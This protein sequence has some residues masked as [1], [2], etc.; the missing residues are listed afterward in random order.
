MDV[1]RNGTSVEQCNL[2]NRATPQNTFKLQLENISKSFGGIKAVDNVSLEISNGVY[3][4]VGKNGAGKTTLV[5]ILMGALEPDQGVIKI[6]GNEVVFRNP[7][8]AK[9]YNI[10]MVF[11]ELSLFPNL[12]IMENISM[13]NRFPSYPVKLIN[14]R[15]AREYTKKCLERVNLDHDPGTKVEELS[16]AEQQMVEIAKAIQF[17]PSVLILDEP[18]SALSLKEQD[19]LYKTIRD[20][21]KQVS[22]IIIITHNL[23]EVIELADR[24]IVMRDGGKIFNKKVNS[25]SENEIVEAIVGKKIDEKKCDQRNGEAQKVHHGKTPL[26]KVQSLSLVRKFENMSFDVSYGEILG[27]VGL[28]GCGKSELA[29]SLFGKEACITGQIELEGKPVCFRSPREAVQRKIGYVP[30]DRKEEGL[31]HG[32]SMGGNI[33]LA[34]LNR[35]SRGGFLR[36]DMEKNLCY[37]M[38]NYMDI[39]PPMIKMTAETFSGGNQQKIILGRWL[40]AN[41]KVLI[42]DEPTRGVDVAS[43]RMIY[44]LL[45][46]LASRGLGI[47]VVSSE[48]KEVHNEADRLMVMSKGKIIQELRPFECSWEDVLAMALRGEN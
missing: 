47:V 17:N 25:T 14:W 28:E 40:A 19:T 20:L 10:A 26:L 45:K 3:A 35:V 2:T 48:F 44:D 4:I 11:Q 7:R 43:K 38:I 13:A 39:N 46:D 23:K 5:N 16:L 33:C 8:D 30:R 15:Q 21:E 24:V 34:A 9:K 12:S 27:I 37:S 29:S 42:L 22:A 18:T 1:G 31:V 36:K 6:N 41:I 32:M